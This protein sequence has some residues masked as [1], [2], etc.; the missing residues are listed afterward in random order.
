[1]SMTSNMTSEERIKLIYDIHA[2]LKSYYHESAEIREQKL[3]MGKHVFFLKLD[4]C[5]DG[6]ARWKKLIKEGLPF[7]WPTAHRYMHMYLSEQ[8]R[9]HTITEITY[10]RGIIVR[11]ERMA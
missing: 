1:M 8:R 9:L 4:Y 11:K 2:H 6:T 7:S 10:E 3:E 5:R